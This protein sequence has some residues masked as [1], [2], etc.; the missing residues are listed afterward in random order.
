MIS[1]FSSLLNRS[2][3]ADPPL[4]LPL[5]NPVG[6]VG[7]PNQLGLRHRMSHRPSPSCPAPRDDP[8]LEAWRIRQEAERERLRKMTD[9]PPVPPAR[10][11]KGSHLRNVAPPPEFADGGEVPSPAPHPMADRPLPKPPA[12]DPGPSPEPPEL[13]ARSLPSSPL[14]PSNE[15]ISAESLDELR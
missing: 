6:A 5:S 13:P 7:N 8:V 9:R 14:K 2:E 11:P 1:F 3:L 12:P 4:G 10:P 15:E